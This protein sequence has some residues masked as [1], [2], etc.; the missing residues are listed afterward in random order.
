MKQYLYR[1]QRMT[2]GKFVI[3]ALLNI[4]NSGFTYMATV[5]AMGKMCV[6]ELDGGKTTNLKLTRVMIHT[7]EPYVEI[8]EKR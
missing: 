3:G 5:E 7:V 4:P 1:A 2:D 8:V 6:N